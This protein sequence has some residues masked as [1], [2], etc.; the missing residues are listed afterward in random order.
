M[1]FAKIERLKRERR[2]RIAHEA[3]L[4]KAREQE[5][6]RKKAEANNKTKERPRSSSRMCQLP[7]WMQWF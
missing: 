6:A 4:K 2:E 7:A 5:L 3:Q 1:V